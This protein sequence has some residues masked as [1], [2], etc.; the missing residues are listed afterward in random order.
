MNM[1]W[2]HIDDSF[3]DWMRERY[4]KRVPFS[5]YGEYGYKPFFGTLFAVNDLIYVTQISSPKERHANMKQSLD[6]YK[7]YHPDDDSLIAVVNLNYMFPA[8]NSVLEDLEYKNLN[9]YRSFDDEK[10]KSKYID[11]LRMELQEI[12]KLNLTEAA[13][14]I[15][16]LK[17]TAPDSRVSLRCFDFKRLEVGCSKYASLLIK[18]CSPHREK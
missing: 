16:Q 8:P 4:E 5:D 14:K 1:I 17:Y 11:F 6:F 15:Y 7:I 12:N 3:L 10:E 13:Q 2:K 9:K 18:S